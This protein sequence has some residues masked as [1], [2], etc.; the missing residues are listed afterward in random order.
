MHSSGLRDCSSESSI[1][2]DGLMPKHLAE[3]LLELKLHGSADRFRKKHPFSPDVAATHGV[4]FSPNYSK[5]KKLKAYREWLESNQPCVFGRVAAKNKLVF[6]CLLEES[7][8]FRMSRGD[9]DLH[10]TI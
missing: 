1:N 4:L 3:L 7:E 6:V 5:R 9:E 2:R 10:D 8:I